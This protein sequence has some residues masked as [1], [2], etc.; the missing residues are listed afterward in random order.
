MTGTE[1]ALVFDSSDVVAGRCAPAEAIYPCAS[2]PGVS[3]LPAPQNGE[4]L[5]PEHVMRRLVPMLKRYFDRVIPGF[6]GRRGARL[7]RGCRR[8]GQRADRV[9]PRPRLHPRRG[10]RAPP[11]H[12][13]RQSP[14]SASS[15]TAFQEEYFRSLAADVPEEGAPCPAHAATWTT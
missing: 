3:L 12:R 11:A 15:S 1:E 5:V 6:A 8:C 4:D 10:H 9:Q 7:P 14:G 2:M 13:A